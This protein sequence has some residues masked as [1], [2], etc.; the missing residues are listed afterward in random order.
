MT[1]AAGIFNGGMLGNLLS[2]SSDHLEVPNPILIG[3][4]ADGIAFNLADAFI[5]TGNLMLMV[6]LCVLTIRYR[7]YL[8]KR[9]DS[10][11]RGRV[12]H[13]L[14]PD[15]LALALR[16]VHRT[17]GLSHQVFDRRRR[18]HVGAGEADARALTHLA[19]RDD[20]HGA[21]ES[22]VDAIRHRFGLGHA[23]GRQDDCELVAAQPADRAG[24]VDGC[25]EDAGDLGEDVVA[26]EMAVLV[27]DALE[28]VEVEEDE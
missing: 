25:T 20:D 3:N 7:D 1:I 14:Q 16:R 5:L 4:H 10:G 2:A 6:S 9:R 24:A 21:G 17:V 28:V 26:A 18:D 12:G 8:P 27:V 19:A 11:L 22:R 15:R 13:E 23:A